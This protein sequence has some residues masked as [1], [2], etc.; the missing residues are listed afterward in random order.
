MCRSF[1]L[2]LNPHEM[3]YKKPLLTNNFLL[4]KEMITQTQNIVVLV[5]FNTAVPTQAL[6]LRETCS[7]L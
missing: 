3:L 2:H 1:S 7:L 4:D 5:Q 6:Q